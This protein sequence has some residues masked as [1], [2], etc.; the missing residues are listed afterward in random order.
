MVVNVAFQPVLASL[1]T[2]LPSGSQFEFT[3][4]LYW[5]TEL[6]YPNRQ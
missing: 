3:V 5:A 1:P 4:N 2:T 6:R